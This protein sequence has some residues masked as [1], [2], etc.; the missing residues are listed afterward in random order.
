MDK[1]E[2]VRITSTKMPE[3]IVKI[4]LNQL[5]LKKYL[6]MVVREAGLLF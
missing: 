1:E 3:N 6:R 5:I 2:T 4:L